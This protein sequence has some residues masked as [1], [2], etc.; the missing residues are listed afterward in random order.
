MMA[1]IKLAAGVVLAVAV[2]AWICVLAASALTPDDEWD[3]DAGK[4]E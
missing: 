2:L 4:G 3:D 1:T